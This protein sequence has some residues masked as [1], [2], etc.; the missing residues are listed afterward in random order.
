MTATATKAIRSP[1]RA[2]YLPGPD[3]P[4]CVAGS[5][6]VCRRLTVLIV[7]LLAH[8]VMSGALFLTLTPARRMQTP[9]EMLFIPPVV[10]GAAGCAAVLRSLSRPGAA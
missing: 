4:R 1:P 7:G 2:R 9:G 3:S 5:S 10:A 6:G 8:L